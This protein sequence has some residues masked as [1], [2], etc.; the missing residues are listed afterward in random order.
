[1]NF[2]SRATFADAYLIKYEESMRDPD[3]KIALVTTR[4]NVAY[5]NQHLKHKGI[6]QVIPESQI[7]VHCNI[8]YP[9]QSPFQRP[10]N[11]KL[12]QYQASGLIDF[13]AS[14]FV[15]LKFAQNLRPKPDPTR[16]LKMHD[17]SATFQTLA[18]GC[19]LSAVVFIGE[20]IYSR[21]TTV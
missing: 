11:D 13:W 1:M 7:L 17:L 5:L 15:N 14:K 20:L 10:F 18:L 8:F 6:L 12:L 21:R 16:A 19:L 3:T 2:C 4:V 9:K